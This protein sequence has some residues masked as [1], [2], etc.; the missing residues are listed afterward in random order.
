MGELLV[1]GRVNMKPKNCFLQPFKAFSGSKLVI[2]MKFGG[3]KKV[4]DQRIPRI[5]GRKRLFGRYVSCKLLQYC[6][7]S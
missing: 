2:S 5:R 4:G 7:L 6:S 3:A 1:S